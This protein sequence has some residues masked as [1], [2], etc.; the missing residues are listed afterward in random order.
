MARRRRKSGGGS[1]RRVSV[2]LGGAVVLVVVLAVAGLFAMWGWLK[3]HL[4]G[5]EFRSMVSAKTSGAFKAK[6]EFEEIH[7]TGSSAYSDGFSARGYEDAPFSSIDANGIRAYVDFGAVRDGVWKVR[8]IDVNL[9][10]LVV[11]E[12]GRLEG[13]AAQREENG[14]AGEERRGFPGSLLPGKVEIGEVAIAESNLVAE[15]K[16]AA[17]GLPGEKISLTGVRTKLR[18]VEGNAAWSVSGSGGSLAIPGLPEFEIDTFTTR[19]R[20][21]DLFVTDAAFTFHEGARLT[22]SGEIGF[23]DGGQM[24]LKLKMADLDTKEILSAVWR[25]KVSGLLHGDL[26]IGRR[27][28]EAMR[29]KGTLY[30]TKGVIE[31][32]EVLERVADYAKAERFRRLVLHEASADFEE[33]GGRIAIGNLVL[34]SDGLTRLTG[35]L[36]IEGGQMTGN[37]RVGVTPGT[38]K[39]IPGAEQKIFIEPADGFLWTHMRVTGPVENPYEDLSS[40]LK[41]A[42][43]Q[44]I[45]EDGVKSVLGIVPG[46]GTK[47]AGTAVETGKTLIDSAA[48]ILNE[49]TGGVSEEG[50]KAATGV[51]TPFLK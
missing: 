29:R 40:R 28:E 19:L 4:Q 22:A 37:F 15:L 5:E 33:S 51:L 9:V 27:G 46:V 21:G 8:E 23:G 14:G 50:R 41:T 3:V 26:E 10:N 49:V 7:W 31:D 42:A 34:Q 16:N 6:G 18:P 39:W 2:I 44:T 20:G 30:L 36:V 11:N 32:L 1:A 43:V 47:A 17:P 48:G 24:G 13:T 35:E 45:A 12:K 25:E 38:L